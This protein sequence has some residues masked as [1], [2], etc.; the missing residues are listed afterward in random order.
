MQEVVGVRTHFGALVEYFD[1]SGI[2]L[3]LGDMVLVEC[4]EGTVEAE[5]VILPS[6]VV[7]DDLERPLRVVLHRLESDK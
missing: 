5:V 4:E 7:F 6:Q 2:P 1:P 3:M